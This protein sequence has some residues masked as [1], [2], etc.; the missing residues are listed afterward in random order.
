MSYLSTEGR[1]Q[2]DT[3]FANTGRH[4]QRRATAPAVGQE[5]IYS[6]SDSRLYFER[7]RN[8]PTADHLYA[9][10]PSRPQ[11]AQLQAVELANWFLA[12]IPMIG[13]KEMIGQ[14]VLVGLSGRVASRTDTSGAGERTAKRLKSTGTQD[15][16]LKAT[17]F[18]VALSYDDI[19][20]WAGLGQG[21]FEQL[22]M[23]AVRDAIASDM[24][25]AGWTGTSAAASTNIGTNPLLQDLAIGW[26]QKIRSYNAGSQHHI[27]TV[28]V[29]ITIGSTGAYKNLD[30]AVQDAKLTVKKQ[31]RNR[32][33]LVALISDNLV[34]SQEGVY[35]KTNGNIA[36]EKMVLD[37]AIRKGYG[38][39]P[40]IVPPFLPDGAILI[41]PLTNLAI[42]YQ[43][44]SVRRLQRDWPTKNEIQD[45]NSMN[46]DY[47]V[48][49]EN[50]TSLVENITLV[51]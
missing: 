36:T 31:F 23:Q 5:L 37:G 43:N 34:N 16:N 32:T 40:T 47:V 15:F 39:L 48:Q 26:L 30:H 17:E 8:N 33:D 10:T 21:V 3:L 28:G 35:Y 29:P 18:D 45:F 27:G 50:A 20:S 24:L 1:Q 49:D 12:M 9:A 14:K 7:L 11:T 19:D 42:Y 41:T 2:L 22:Y 38:G 13:V 25:Q 44:S 51:A 4:F 6:R 46:L